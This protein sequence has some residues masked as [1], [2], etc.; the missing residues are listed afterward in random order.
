VLVQQTAERVVS[1]HLVLALLADHRQS[2]GRVWRL[3]LQRLMRT[4][5]VVVPDLDPKDLLEVAAP[6]NE[7]PVQTL[8][9]DRAHPALG[10]GVRPWCPYWRDQDLGAF[11]ADHVV[12]GAGD[13][14]SRSGSNERSRGPRSP[15]TSS[16]LRPC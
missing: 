11:V 4:V 3:E 14:A 1:M 16:R 7:Q 10:V 2:G 12:E 13:F 6:N 8:G 15:S 9:A 5:P